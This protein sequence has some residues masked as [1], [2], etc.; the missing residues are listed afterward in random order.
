MSF[1]S[2]YG[3][4][5]GASFIIVKQ[6]DGLDIPQ[7]AGSYVYKV[8]YLAVTTDEQYFI[9]DNGFIE[10]NANNYSDYIWKAQALDGSTVDT[11]PDAAGT[12]PTSQQVLDI[13]YAE[14]MRQ[15]FEQGGDTTDIVNYGEYVIIDTIDK[16]DPDNGKVY[17]RG[18]N[19][20][21]NPDTNPLAGAEYIGQIVGPQGV[22]PELNFDHYQDIIDEYGAAAP[23]K[24]YDEANED[25]VPGSYID[26]GVR[27]FNDEI[28]YTYVTIK[29]AFNNV[30]GC[31]IGFQ[32]PYL[33]Q[34]L[35]AQ[36]MS[37]YENRA[38]DPDT[39]KY[40]NYDLI[41]E[42]PTQYIDD[43]WIHPFYQKWQIKI[44]SGYHGVDSTNI[45]IVHTKTMPA[46]FKDA[47]F[48]GAAL[49]D[50]AACTIPH[51]ESGQPV[52][53]PTAADVLREAEGTIYLS[54]DTPIYDASDDVISCKVEY[55][56]QEYYVKKEDCYMDVVRY[57]QT[58][59][60]N[61]E[62]G[63][64]T[65][66]YIGDYNIIKR[67][68]LAADGTLTAFY[69]ANPSPQE[70]E[71]VIR[72][73][74]TQDT[75]GITIDADG[76]VKVYYNTLDQYGNHEY[77]EFPNVLDWITRV[78]LTQ[79]GQFTVLFNNNTI[80]GGRYDATLEWIDFVE[81]SEDGVVSFYYNTN[82]D[83]PAYTALDRI[84]YISDME[85]ETVAEGETYEGTGDQK[86]HVTYN[87]GDSEIIGNP[88]NYI[89]E[90]TISTPSATYPD[91]PY[92]HLL[93]YYADPDL[94]Q[95]LSSKWVTFPSE[96]YPG[97]VWTEWVDLGN[98]R[99]AAGGIHIIKDVATESELKDPVTGNW[100]PP[101]LLE[102]SHGQVIQPDGAGWSVTLTPAG[103]TTSYFY[104]Y[105]YDTEEWYPI[106]NIDPGAVDPETLLV[107]STPM[108]GTQDP[109]PADVV[110]LK[111][112]GFWLASETAYYA[113]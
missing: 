28:K 77:Q 30:K 82:H 36:S 32:L 49:Y 103:S 48:R 15:C 2:F 57:R 66:Y 90:T 39:G 94:R 54:T 93:V 26:D 100:I 58:D 40:Y 71:E 78:T 85:I 111:P 35:E 33:I 80:Q 46:Q 11:K 23:R 83:Y 99:G 61:L 105:D 91:A 37:P 62:D 25:I 84:K 86:L 51:E 113:Y 55:N 19:F 79:N 95:S 60:D 22:S 14:G 56:G 110:K 67:I 52:V 10:K 63:E 44:P 96:K 20:D 74:D 21:Y 8:K 107:K 13:A 6:F 18:I 34:D 53:L 106:G 109:V 12:G 89:I 75:Q 9:Y 31:L 102:D 17:R 92:S 59:Y 68:Q 41:T 97:E 81:I 24:T 70:L 3:G 5:Q 73:I 101:E 50:D 16:N 65:Y 64:I 4:R 108:S 7:A 45:E 88:L 43:K 112:E 1:S 27:E 72:W 98:V 47:T 87:T 69:T 42:D 104:C 29:D 76:T 38:V